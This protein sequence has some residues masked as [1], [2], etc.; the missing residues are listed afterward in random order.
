MH[1]LLVYTINNAKSIGQFLQRTT[2]KRVGGVYL[3]LWKILASWDDSSKYM[4][5]YKMFQTTNQKKHD[6]FPMAL[7]GW[8]PVLISA[9]GGFRALLQNRRG[10]FLDGA[11]MAKE[12]SKRCHPSWRS[13]KCH[14][15]TESN[16]S[17]LNMMCQKKNVN[18]CNYHAQLLKYWS[19]DLTVQFR[20]Q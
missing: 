13:S 12:D 9:P 5:K 19:M 14:I 16:L 2:T 8:S 17:E 10:Y 11:E 15:F 7:A 18:N 1:I 3:P 4:E 6:L 20:D